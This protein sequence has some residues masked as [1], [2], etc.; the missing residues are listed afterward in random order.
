MQIHIYA[1]QGNSEGVVQET[2]N[3]AEI[4]RPD[5][6]K[7]FTPLMY[8]V[9][10]EQAGIELVQFLVD[11]GADVNAIESEFQQPVL[12]LAIQSGNL[13]K[14]QLILDLGANINY[15]R[16]HGYDALI[17]AMCIVKDKNLLPILSLLL[18][19]G[20]KVNGI[21]SYGETALKKASRVGRFDAV[22]LLLKAGCDRQQLKWTTLMYAIVFGKLKDVNNL[23]S[24]KV[25]LNARDYWQ[26]TPWLLS[27]E[28][29]E[30]DK[31]K[32]ILASGANSRDRGQGGK[33]ALM[34][35]NRTQSF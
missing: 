1:K 7:F 13:P 6:K 26:R 17:D 23:L 12:G 11:R 27:I 22:H 4:D 9:T 8:A 18:E 3:G 34:Y 30:I 28:A 15:Q 21:S 20:A 25:D 16:P 31:A 24:K 5:E 19:R 2:V 29:G 35:A 33:T 14:I 32:L 10:C